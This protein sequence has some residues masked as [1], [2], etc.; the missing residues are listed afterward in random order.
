MAYC[1]IVSLKKGKI[2]NTP[3]RIQE[4]TINAMPR[5]RVNLC[6]IQKRYK[7]EWKDPILYKY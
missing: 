1:L 7:P 5:I 2:R 6:F 4:N 3:Q